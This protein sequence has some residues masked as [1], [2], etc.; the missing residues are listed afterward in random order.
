[1]AT[2]KPI[3]PFKGAKLVAI[4]R[5][6][7]KALAATRIHYDTEPRGEEFEAFVMAL[8]ESFPPVIRY[9][10]F[11]ASVM[12]MV[13]KRLTRDLLHATSW[14]LAGNIDK[15]KK[16]TPVSQ[17]VRQTEFEWCPITIV[18]A[19]PGRNYSGKGG[20]FFEYRVMAGT[21][22]GLKFTTFWTNPHV[23]FISKSAGF[24]RTRKVH[25]KL[26]DGS[27]MVRMRLYLLFDPTL[28]KDDRPIAY[29]FHVP[30]S[31]KTHNRRILKQRYRLIPCPL[32]YKL[33]EVKCHQC[34]QGYD[35]CEAGCHPK[36]FYVKA[37]PRCQVGETWF[38]PL[39][40]GVVCVDCEER[41]KRTHRA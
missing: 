18:R 14:R 1:M 38:D 2:D 31:C 5:Q 20:Y 24:S 10:V 39:G 16:G 15:L 25:F 26:H 7:D 32:N 12:D 30:A 34:P 3:T 27:E 28:S 6:I 21:P 8:Y 29:K 22:A 4:Q 19:S 35:K 40:R 33:S 41:E 11:F 9:D 36:T 37:C 23:Q 13:G 17:W